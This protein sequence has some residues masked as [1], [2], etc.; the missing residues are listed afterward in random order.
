[1]AVVAVAAQEAALVTFLHYD[2]LDELQLGGV[3]TIVHKPGHAT[4][5]AGE[6]LRPRFRVVLELCVR[7]AVVERERVLLPRQN[8]ALAGFP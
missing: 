6:G 8:L 1:M 5:L 2:G 3:A 7:V 4:I